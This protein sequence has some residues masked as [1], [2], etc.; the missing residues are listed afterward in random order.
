MTVETIQPLDDLVWFK[1]SDRGGEPAGLSTN[2]YAL[3]SDSGAL[4]VDTMFEFLLPTVAQLADRGHSPVGLMLTHRHVASNGDIFSR[5]V[6]TYPVPLLLHPAD[7]AHP[8]A[9]ASGVAF[10]DPHASDLPARFGLEVLDFPGQTEGSIALYRE[11]DGLFIAGDAAMGTT[12]A[13][14]EN[15]LRRLVR[16]PLHT[17]VD[18]AQLRAG[19]LVFDRPLRHVAPLHGTPQFDQPDLITLMRPLSREAPTADMHGDPGDLAA[20]AS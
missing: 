10:G 12:T 19:W 11:R 20:R 18:D 17:S 2:A 16:P 4:L 1:H 6:E 7:A 3:V 14:A 5:F 9:K 15:G 13:Q 8:Q